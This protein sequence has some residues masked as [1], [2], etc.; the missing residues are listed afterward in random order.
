[1]ATTTWAWIAL[2]DSV[3]GAPFHTFAV[4]GGI[5]AFTALHVALNVVYGIAIM[6]TIHA[7]RRTPSLIIGAI[8]MYLTFEFM[9]AMGTI[10]LSHLGLGDLAWLRIFGASLVGSAVAF[11]LIAKSHPLAARL[12]EA[13]QER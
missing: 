5:V 10:L 3:V 4:L 8:F 2:V 9:F 11:V 7:S 13:E 12:R 1:M 6:S